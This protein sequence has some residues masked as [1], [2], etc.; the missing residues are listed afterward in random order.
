MIYCSLCYSQTVEKEWQICDICKKDHARGYRILSLAG[1]CA[2]GA[3]RDHG[4]IYHAVKIGEY[5]A[6][7]GAK[8][9]RRSAGWS[10]WRPVDVVTCPRCLAKIEKM[11]NIK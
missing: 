2:N 7:C 4:R 3:E 11:E 9:G 8:P 5:T 10:S 6:F 1:R